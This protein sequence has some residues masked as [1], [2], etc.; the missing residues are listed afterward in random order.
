MRGPMVG[1]HRPF[2]AQRLCRG[3]GGKREI[4]LAVLRKY[5]GR[6]RYSDDRLGLK[7]MLCAADHEQWQQFDE[8]FEAYWF[9]KGRAA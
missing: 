9:A 1:L 7:T 5:T 2:A 4:A 6:A 8:L 3:A